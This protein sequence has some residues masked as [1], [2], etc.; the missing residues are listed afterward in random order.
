[1]SLIKPEMIVIAVSLIS[2]AFGAF[3]IVWKI[4]VA[5]TAMRAELRSQIERANFDRALSD[6]RLEDLAKKLEIGL[7]ALKDRVELLS[8]WAK[9]E[10][11]DI[12]SRMRHVEG[13]FSKKNDEP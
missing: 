8:L 3:M 12:E 11:R 7:N 13:A 9:D 2:S 1:M 10:F 5:V 4:G 6:Q